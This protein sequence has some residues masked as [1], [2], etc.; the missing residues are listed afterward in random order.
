MAMFNSYVGLPEGNGI[1]S[2]FSVSM[3]F[4]QVVA[5][6][7]LQVVVF[8][9]QERKKGDFSQRIWETKWISSVNGV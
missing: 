4:L 9:V 6:F 8:F 5:V 3:V 1:I 7:F 2:V